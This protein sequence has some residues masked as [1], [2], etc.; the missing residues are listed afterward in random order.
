M[1]VKPTILSLLGVDTSNDIE[2]GHD[3]FAPDR[4]PFVVFRDGN[5]VTDK[6]YYFE[7]HILR[8]QHW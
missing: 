1:D 3:L 4:K 8:P 2:F 7:K 5:F 6:Y